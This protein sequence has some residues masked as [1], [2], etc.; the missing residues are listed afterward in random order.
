MDTKMKF[1][2][3][4]KICEKYGE[5][6]NSFIEQKKYKI[7]NYKG[8]INKE[9]Y[10]QLY[11]MHYY[12]GKYAKKVNRRKKHNFGE[13]L[14]DIVA[15]YLNIFLDKKYEIIL[16]ESK[17]RFQPDILI[18]KN[19]NNHFII[20]IKTNLGWNRKYIANGNLAKRIRKMAK[21]FDIEEKNIIYI[22]ETPG[23][24]NGEF[25]KRYWNKSGPQEH[26][27]EKLYNQ[28]YPLFNATDPYYM[29][30][31]F[32][33]DKE[34]IYN[35]EHNNIV[36]DDKKIEELAKNNIIT[37]FKVIIDLITNTIT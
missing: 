8:D 22:F 5:F 32:K 29:V 13:I 27:K 14:Q 20:E 37:N 2:E 3:R 15:Y 10:H 16:E 7:S 21:V 33:I 19:G 12:A 28:I 11:K 6:L 30:S 18:T 23:N 35:D 24:V 26:P 1:E 17:K 31:E 34:K 4:Y 25:K 9:I 36:I